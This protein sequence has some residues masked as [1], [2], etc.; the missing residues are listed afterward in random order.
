MAA[1]NK[2]KQLYAIAEVFPSCYKLREGY[3]GPVQEILDIMPTLTTRCA[4][5]PKPSAGR[6]EG[7][8][9]S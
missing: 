9:P 4:L 1:L 6:S 5:L 7:C 2:H 8:G 3:L